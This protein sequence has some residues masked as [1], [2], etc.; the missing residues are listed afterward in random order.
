LRC[1]AWGDGVG[2]SRGQFLGLVFPY[3]WRLVLLVL[4]LRSFGI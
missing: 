1:G 4:H 2:G 3:F